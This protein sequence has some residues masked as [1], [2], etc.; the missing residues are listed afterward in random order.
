MLHYFSTKAPI[1]V[2]VTA[3]QLCVDFEGVEKTSPTAVLCI[4]TKPIGSFY[5]F[6]VRLV[7]SLS[8]YYVLYPELLNFCTASGQALQQDNSSM[9]HCTTLQPLKHN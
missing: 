7:Y 3:M 4:I 2:Q 6:Y 1:C 8:D 5:Y 9:L